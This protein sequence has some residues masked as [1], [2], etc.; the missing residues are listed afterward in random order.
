MYQEGTKTNYRRSV[1]SDRKRFTM[2]KMTETTIRN[3]LT[4]ATVAKLYDTLVNAGFVVDRTKDLQTLTFEVGD[5]DSGTK[6]Y[7][8]YGS[9]K[10]TL[11]KSDFVLDDAIKEYE[12]TVNEREEKAKLLAEKKAKAEADRAAKKAKREAEKALKQSN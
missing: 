5:V 12:A 2:A 6:A 4:T 3:E 11:H 1:K 8:A 7:T 9:I 10:F